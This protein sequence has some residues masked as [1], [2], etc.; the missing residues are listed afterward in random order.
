MK[1]LTLLSFSLL[2]SGFLYGQEKWIRISPKLELQQLSSETYAHLS[3]G[4]NG[5]LTFSNGEAI[6]VSSPPTKEATA[7]LIAWIKDSLKATLVAVVIDSWHYDNMEGL[8]LFHDQGIKSYANELTRKIAQQKGLPVPNIGFTEKL[9]LKVGRKTLVAHYFGPAHTSDGIVAWLPE[10]RILFGNN[11][12]R[13]F[14]GWVGNIGDANFEK[15]SETLSKVKAC[16]GNAAFVIPGHG[17]P[18]GSELLDYTIKLY[19][20]NPWGTILK[21]H[22]VK[23]TPVFNEFDKVFVSAHGDSA[24]GATHIL[25][26]ALIFVDKGEQY[27]MIES[28]WVNYNSVTRSIRS[29][30]GRIRIL[31]KEKNSPLPETDGYYKSLAVDLRDDAIGITIVIRELMR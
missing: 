18:G 15:W 24:K 11:G 28:P 23:P 13:N 10:E 17:S 21:R 8:E 19:S 31:N 12:V 5:M 16:Y 20:P 7:E 30:Y 1:T 29:D 4:S 3:E 26:H 22:E 14:N 2:L 25:N 27:L 9:E 6:V